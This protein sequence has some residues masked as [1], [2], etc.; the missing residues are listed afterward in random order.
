M[1][2]CRAVPVRQQAGSRGGRRHRHGCCG[3]QNSRGVRRRG[4]RHGRRADRLSGSPGGD[5]R[6]AEKSS[7]DDAVDQ[8]GGPVHAVFCCRR[9]RGRPRRDAGELHRSPPPDRANAGQGLP[10]PRVRDLLH[11]VSGRHRVGERSAARSGIRRQRPTTT[12]ADA[13]V[14]AHEPEGII[15]YELQQAGD[16]RVRGMAGLS[17][18]GQGDVAST[19]SAPDPTDTPLAR[20]NADLWLGVRPGLPRTPPASASINLSR[21]PTRWCSST[22]TPRAVST[23]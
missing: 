23:A 17:P 3:S 18:T 16:Q 1:S 11:L 22:A 4:H 2:A 21:W 19:Q 9:H 10:A 13:W 14:P 5:R 7:I 12:A 8:V 6:L 15:H 20:A